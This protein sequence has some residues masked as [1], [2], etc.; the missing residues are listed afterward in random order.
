[1]AARSL[2]ARSLAA[3][4]LV[5]SHPSGGRALAAFPY[6]RRAWLIRLITYS[7]VVTVISGT[8]AARAI[9]EMS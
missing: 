3:R 4:S 5:L 1:L 2:A 6:A 9:R 7:V 8:R